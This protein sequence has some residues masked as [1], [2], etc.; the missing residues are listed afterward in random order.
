SVRLVLDAL[1]LNAHQV[2]R[3]L[4]R[5][6][7][8]PIA[9]LLVERG[10]TESQRAQ[11]RV[12]ATESPSFSSVVNGGT[13]S[14][15]FSRL[16]RPVYFRK[17]SLFLFRR[18]FRRDENSGR[19]FPARRPSGLLVGQGVVAYGRPRHPS[20]QCRPRGDRRGPVSRRA[21]GE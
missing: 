5:A 21:H 1:T 10:G 7:G 20:D 6:T 13:Y 4:R 17:T 14:A 8:R 2:G 18:S 15:G 9:G 12:V 3:L 11:W 19:P 16:D